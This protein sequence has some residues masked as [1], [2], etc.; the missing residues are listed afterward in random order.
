MANMTICGQSYKHFTLV[1]YDS[2]VVIWG[3]F[4]SMFIRLATGKGLAIKMTSYYGWNAPIGTYNGDLH[5]V[6]WDEGLSA[7]MTL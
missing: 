5:E 7:L 4:Q 2:R 1:N 6:G 3:I